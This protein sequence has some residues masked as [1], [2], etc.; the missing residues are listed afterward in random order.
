MRLN[1]SASVPDKEYVTEDPK[2]SLAEIVPTSVV[3]SSIV[4]VDSELNVGPSWS[5]SVMST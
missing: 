1:D 4:N 2:G 3:F 5:I